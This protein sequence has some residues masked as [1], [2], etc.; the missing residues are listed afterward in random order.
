V[1][2]R[3]STR[4]DAMARSVVSA[5][6]AAGYP[7]NDVSRLGR[8]IETAMAPRIERLSDDHHP[9]F[10]H[11]GRSV[12]VLVRDV[13]AVPSE[14]LVVAALLETEDAELRV[15]M[16]EVARVG[17]RTLDDLSAMPLPGDERLM[18][19]LVGLP[20]GLALAV[21]AER[22]D[23]LRHLHL[24]E[25]LWP[26]WVERH[27]EVVEAWLPFAERAEPGLAT[28]FGH[29]ER[30]FRRRLQSRVGLG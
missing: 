7:P 3:A 10:L 22:L 6:R 17:P 2:E 9:A 14:T 15:S 27:R 28:R 30:T 13:G 8:A 12:L 29:W 21:L 18:E 4:V 23:H 26:H 24:R 1:I 25:D 20:R 5:T 11:P 16:D 19:R